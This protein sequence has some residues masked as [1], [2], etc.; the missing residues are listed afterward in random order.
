M[1][2]DTHITL[3]QSRQSWLDWA[4]YLARQVWKLNGQSSLQRIYIRNA[5]HAA[6][7]AQ[8]RIFQQS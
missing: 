7:M 3:A 4:D 2:S 6:R 8:Q 5:R 1:N